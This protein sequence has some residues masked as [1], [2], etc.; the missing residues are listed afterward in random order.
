MPSVEVLMRK[1]GVLIKELE[2]GGSVHVKWINM[3][4][5]DKIMLDCVH[6]EI[7][8]ASILDSSLDSCRNAWVLTDSSKKRG[9]LDLM[10]YKKTIE[11]INYDPYTS[12]AS[13]GEIP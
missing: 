6:A 5:L 4:P 1:I 11:E 10:Y 3:N 13:S 2:Q 12:K 8:G 7:Q 9:E